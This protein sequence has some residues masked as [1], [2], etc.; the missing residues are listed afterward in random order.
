MN[1]RLIEVVPALATEYQEWVE[2]YEGDPVGP[3]IPYADLV[4]HLR[5]LLDEGGHD[6]Y[7]TPILAFIEELARHPDDDVVTLVYVEV[8]EGLLDTFDEEV[9]KRTI[10][11]MGPTTRQI[12]YEVAES[13][14]HCE[15]IRRLLNE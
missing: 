1:K 4:R 11:L 3:Y 7:L 5:G 13:R 14:R 9:L 6:D 2:L 12:A 15:Q 8:V 10:R